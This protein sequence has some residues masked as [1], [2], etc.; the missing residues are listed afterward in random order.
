MA[1]KVTCTGWQRGSHEVDSVETPDSKKGLHLCPDCLTAY[2]ID[3]K[4]GVDSRAKLADEE[5]T[6]PRTS[7]KD[8]K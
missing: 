8:N 1:G 6:A 2:A 5:R 3:K 7:R 4:M